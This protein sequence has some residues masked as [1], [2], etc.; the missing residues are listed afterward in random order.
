[1]SP[2]EQLAKVL[3]GFPSYAVSF[4]VLLLVAILSDTILT[5]LTI[6]CVLLAVLTNVGIAVVAFFGMYVFTRTINTIANAIGV[7][8]QNL[9]QALMPPPM[10]HFAEHPTQ[11]M[12]PPP[13]AETP[14]T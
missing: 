7:S 14:S 4:V 6:A 12:P 11:E 13:P 3:E 1:M 2:L 9:T 5:S 10:P 8:G